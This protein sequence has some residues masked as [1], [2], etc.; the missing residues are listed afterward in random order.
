MKNILCLCE[1]CI[2]AIQSHD[3]LYVGCQTEDSEKTICDWCNDE[4]DTLYECYFQ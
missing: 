2:E 1:Y 3:K 4:D